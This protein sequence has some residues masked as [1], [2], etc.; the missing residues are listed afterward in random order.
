MSPHT[1]TTPPGNANLGLV[2]HCFTLSEL[3]SLKK[4]LGSFDC[5]FSVLLGNRLQEEALQFFMGG[6]VG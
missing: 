1:H 6:C 5:L 3:L 4:R 2:Q